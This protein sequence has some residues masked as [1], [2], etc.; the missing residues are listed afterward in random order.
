VVD[1]VPRVLAGR[2][3]VRDLIGRGGMA[4]VFIGHDRRLSRTV[5]IKVL[6]SDLARDPTFQARFRREAQSAAALNHPAIVSVYDTGEDDVVTPS[7]ATQHVPF[8]V[9]EYVEG[10][11]VR[12]LLSDG[13]PVPIDEAVEIVGGVLAAL[14]YS[15]REGIVHRDIK[16]GNVMLTPTGAVKVMDFGIARAMAD[17]SATMTQ[18][19]AVVGTAQYLSPEQ[20]RGEVVDAR[21]DLYSTGCLLFELLTGR[22]PFSG[23]SAV[24][25]A[26]Q[27]VRE[28]PKPPSSIA[29][30]VPEAVDRVV[31]KSLAK[32]REDRYPDAA[33]MRADLDAA[34]RGGMVRAP[35]V[36]TWAAVPEPA[37]SV[38]AAGEAT[39]AIPVAAAARTTTGPA[40]VEEPEEDRRSPWWVWALVLVGLAAAIGIGYLL[41]TRDAPEDPEPTTV[42]A[43]PELEGLDAA[44]AER[45]IVDEGLVFALGE[46]EPSDTVEEGLYVSSTP[47]V[48]EEVEEGETVTVRFS[49]GPAEVAVPDVIGMSQDQAREALEEDGLTNIRT[50]SVN[51]PEWEQDRVASTE[52]ETGTAVTPDT[53]ITL[54]LAT[55]NVDVPE[56]VG[57]PLDQA[58]QELQAR[59]LSVASVVEQPSGD[60]APGTVIAQ[61]RTGP[62]P[63]FTAITLTVAV[64]AP[65]PEPEPEPTTQAPPPDPGQPTTEPPADGGGSPGAQGAGRS[66]NENAGPGNNNGRGNGNGNGRGN[67]P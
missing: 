26:Y 67:R 65:E 60:Y 48:G 35:A 42:V 37:T 18:T 27:H 1:E 41:L 20:A 7:G 49:A 50:A 28:I 14:E 59:T 8:I 5:A 40:P 16:P 36:G 51:D 3:E 56:V 64:A 11:T 61:D 17:S 62:V 57:M 44:G 24:A 47:P 58:Q 33:A 29:P 63:R 39:R 12:S 32:D 53:V 31:L 19:H 2:Y 46:P 54:N 13:V 52:P 21:S 43:V 22:P 23:D 45:V 10:H 66:G 38:M 4:E 9:M 30:D 25:V 34:V 15:H 55:G 6:R